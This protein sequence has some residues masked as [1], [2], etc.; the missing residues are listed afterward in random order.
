MEDLQ[1]HCVWRD[2]RRAEF[3]RERI[4]HVSC[5]MF[6]HPWTCKL[7]LWPVH[8]LSLA[9]SSTFTFSK[10]QHWERIRRAGEREREWTTGLLNVLQE[11]LF[12]SYVC[13][14][15]GRTDCESRRRKQSLK[16]ESLV[17]THKMRCCWSGE[18]KF[19]SERVKDE[20]H[21]VAKLIWTQAGRAIIIYSRAHLSLPS[22]S[23]SSSRYPS[24]LL[25]LF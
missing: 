13:L 23:I 11:Q 9:F 20:K 6:F 17:N 18:R 7:D 5:L 24:P 19:E 3:G 15:Y 22:S 8:A 21:V 25:L 16:G 1:G 4:V 10:K 12:P 2:K 14:S